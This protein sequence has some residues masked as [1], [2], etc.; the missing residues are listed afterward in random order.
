MNLRL[1]TSADDD[2]LRQAVGK[3]PMPGWIRLAYAREPSFF[4]AQ[5]VGHS[6]SQTILGEEGDGL[7]G[8][9]CRGIRPVYVNGTPCDIGYLSGLR[10]SEEARL[11]MGLARGYR[12][13]HELHAD[14]RVPVYLSTIIDANDEAKTVLT[15]QR[16]GLPVYLDQ[17][18]FLT[19]A[20]ALSP[21]RAPRVVPVAGVSI[22]EGQDVSAR[23]IA[24][25]L[26][27]VGRARQFFPVVKPGDFGTP[28][29]RGLSPTDF[30]VALSGERIV[31]V[32]AKWDQSAFKQVNVCG[33]SGKA[34][35]LR[36][37]MNL[38]LKAIGYV[39]LP[40]PGSELRMLHAAFPCVEGD[41]PAVLQVLLG[42]LC[43]ANRYA[44]FHSLVI[45]FH[46]RDP[47]RHGLAGFLKFEY[48]SRLY[49]VAW[50]DGKPFADSLARDRVPHLE[51][52]TL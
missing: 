1:A 15:S 48:V 7:L 30:A 39:P 36:G 50:E 3:A 10:A 38:A 25:F 13:L 43:E 42:H 44:G 22:R 5:R 46:E 47:L 17:G 4:D 18:R 14:G 19:Y 12:F 33:Y 11:P 40:S 52:A 21:R 9:G 16:A 28:Y 24:D 51:P 6:F 8:F 23:A 26:N 31:G 41:D 2:A 32:V 20:V 34:R 27:R 37:P 35:L 49:V 45:G 29:L